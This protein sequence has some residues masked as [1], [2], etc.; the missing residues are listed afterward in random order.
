MIFKGEGYVNYNNKIYK[1]VDGILEV[2]EADMIDKM[3]EYYEVIV[4]EQEI[5]QTVKEEEVIEVDYSNMTNKEL[6]AILDEKEIAY[7]NRMSKAEL[8]SL[9]KDGE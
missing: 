5:I 6:M 8:I 4:D 1:F 9:L 3:K 2:K 7:N